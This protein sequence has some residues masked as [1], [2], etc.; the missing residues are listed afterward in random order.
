MKLYCY[1]KW[2][3]CKKAVNWLEANDI[4][5][6]Y[7]DITLTPPSATELESLFKQN[8]YPIK[9][10]FNTSGVK[11]RELGVKDLLP[12][13]SEP[14]IFDLLSSDGKLIK[15]PFLVKNQTV[16]IGFKEN[17]YQQLKA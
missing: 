5:F 11:Y 13:L 14:E 2:S 12:N 1:P 16:L 6:E 15:R 10:F 17:L 9:K 4:K 8:D 7:I 3:T